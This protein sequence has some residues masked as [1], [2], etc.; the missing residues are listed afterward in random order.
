MNR[1]NEMHD[2]QQ[3]AFPSYRYV[4][5]LFVI[6]HASKILCKV[7]NFHKPYTW[8]SKNVLIFFR[9]LRINISWFL[10]KSAP[11]NTDWLNW[12]FNLNISIWNFKIFKPSFFT[13]VLYT[14]LFMTA[15]IRWHENYRIY[16]FQKDMN[17]ALWILNCDVFLKITQKQ[18]LNYPVG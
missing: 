15:T 1:T 11:Y 14:F 18:F 12:E 13:V 4:I 8:W 7:S 9:F 6:L 16:H 17:F 3:M 5:K 10:K 2:R